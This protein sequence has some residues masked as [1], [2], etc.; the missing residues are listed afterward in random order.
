MGELNKHAPCF[1]TDI[2]TNNIIRPTKL[3]CGV[4]IDICTAEVRRYAD[5]PGY[6]PLR[7][8]I[9]AIEA[10]GLLIGHNIAS[11]DAPQLRR[12]YGATIPKD[13]LIDTLHACRVLWPDLR[14]QDKNAGIVPPGLIGKHSLKAWG[15]R[16]GHLKDRYGETADWR[17]WSP[18]MMEYCVQDCITTWAVYV[19]ILE[20]DL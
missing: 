5:Q 7:E 19:H 4:L 1:V 16:V 2:E 20:R 13:K 3:H 12:L 14:E 10:A 18:E 6:R 11:Y 17:H 15:Y 8:Y 9:A